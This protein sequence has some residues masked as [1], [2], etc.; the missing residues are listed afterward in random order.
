M[1]IIAV[2]D[3]HGRDTWKKVVDK[4]L[5]FDQFVFVGDYLDDFPPATGESIFKNLVDII[6]FK[7][8][9]PDKVTVLYG[10]HELHYMRPEGEGECY[11]GY[12]S[13]FAMRY[14]VFLKSQRHLMR[15][16]YQ[17]EDILFTHAGVTRTWAH[18]W[19]V[20]PSSTGEL[21]PSINRVFKTMP[22][23]FRFFPGDT[24]RYGED[25][26]QGPLWVRPQSLLADLHPDIRQVVGHTHVEHIEFKGYKNSVALIDTGNA[27][28]DYLKIVDGV[29]SVGTL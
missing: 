5:D 4:E 9:A 29:M 18:T 19:G 11:S 24:S 13:E 14:G 6:T 27:S 3:I 22:E 17:Y 25:G 2:G 23:A 20:L 26:N 8:L 21:A 15:L 16:A 12:N 28:G 1:K 7:R 10:N